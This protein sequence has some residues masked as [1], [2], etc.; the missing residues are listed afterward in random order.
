MHGRSAREARARLGNGLHH[1][2][3]LGDAQ[4][5]A[6]I[7]GWQADAQPAAI[8]ERTVQLVRKAADAVT[9]EPVGIVEAGANFAYGFADGFVFFRCR[10]IHGMRS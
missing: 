4:A 6:T 10:K 2:R 5:T 3:G 7:F 9:L 1:H 8:G